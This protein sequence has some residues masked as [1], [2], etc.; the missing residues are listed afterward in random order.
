MA[1]QHIHLHFVNN[2]TYTNIIKPS[3]HALDRKLHSLPNTQDLRRWY[4]PY[5]DDAFQVE[6]VHHLYIPDPK[7]QSSPKR[8]LNP[9]PTLSLTKKNEDNTTQKVPWQDLITGS[10]VRIVVCLLQT[11]HSDSLV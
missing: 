11:P 5:E 6:F 2:D 10:I 1:K 7:T 4:S 8:I 9:C 3:L